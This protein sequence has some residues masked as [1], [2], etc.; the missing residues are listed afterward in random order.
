MFGPVVPVPVPGKINAENARSGPLLGAGDEGVHFCVNISGSYSLVA[1]AFH[2]PAAHQPFDCRT[3][4]VR[5]SGSAERRI[6][7]P[8]KPCT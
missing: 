3:C 8:E 4:T 7:L 5:P 1:E 2:D 6:T